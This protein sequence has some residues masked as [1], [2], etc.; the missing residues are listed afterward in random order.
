MKNEQPR[1]RVRPY[2]LISAP[3]GIISLIVALFYGGGTFFVTLGVLLLGLAL[4]GFF[5]DR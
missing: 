1:R 5:L 2:A 4:F 3:L